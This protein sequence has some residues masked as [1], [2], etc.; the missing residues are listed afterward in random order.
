MR[1]VLLFLVAVSMTAAHAEAQGR[2][3]DAVYKQV[4]ASCHEGGVPRAASREALGRL[5]SDAIRL[6]LTGGSMKTQGAALS[7]AELD[8]VVKFLAAADPTATSAPVNRCASAAPPLTGALSKPHWN[9][10]GVDISHTRFQPATMAGL[11]AA[12]VPRLQLKWAFGFPN[13]SQAYA[14]PT[15]VGGRVFV[16]SAARKLYALDSRTGCEYWAVDTDA[17]VR[18]A[19]TVAQSAGGWSAYF[20][21]QRAQVYAVDAVTGAIRWKTRLDEHQGAV[22]TGAPTLWDG[23]L[24]VSMSS[25][26]EALGANPKYEC[27]TFRG[28]VS[29]VDAGTGKVIWKTYTIPDAPQP[30]RKNKVGVQRHGP[31][32]APIWSSPTIDPKLRAVYVTTGDN[33][34]DPPTDTSDAFMAFDA[35][36][37]KHLWTKQMTKGDAYT[38]DCDLPEALRANCPEANGPDVDFGSSPILVSLPNGRRALIAGQKSG[39]VHALDPDRQGEVLWQRNVGKGG[40]L[41]GVQWG[42]AADASNVYVALSDV[43]PVPAAPNSPGAQPT[44]FGIPFS[45]DPKAGGGLFALK[46]ETGEVV[47]QTPHPGCKRPGCSPAQ[48]AAVSAMPGIVFSGGLDGY[49]RAYSTADGKI[50]WDVDTLKGFDTVNGAKATGGSIDAAGPV[51]A[52]GMVFVNSGYAFMGSAP[53]NVLLAFSVDGK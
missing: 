14:Q 16:G 39:V 12:D 51:V 17:P 7:P 19:V 43:Q 49:L 46:V 6:A 35:M 9:G 53:G 26:E 22:V 44:V 36:N 28:S 4:C 1:M 45:L 11:S 10:W 33:Y 29:A 25:L 47:W 38:M 21:D 23:R 41:G 20:G 37:G 13:V 15:V 50:V 3:G 42:S 40:K 32:G 18:T 27:C 48:S 34:S 24:Y 52:G 2:D 31:S 8:A 5:S 30:L